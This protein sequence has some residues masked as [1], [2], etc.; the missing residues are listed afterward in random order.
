MT[1]INGILLKVGEEPAIYKLSKDID[2]QIKEI[3]A[4]LDGNFTSSR[5]F[6]VGENLSLHIFIN[7]MAIPLG[8]P[9]NRRFPEPDQHEI[10]FGNALF[11][12]LDDIKG[13]EEGALQIPDQICNLF[14]E[15][16]NENFKPCI[17]NEK[18]DPTSE[19]F[20]ENVGTKEERRF[21]WQEVERPEKDLTFI[22][23]GS[24]RIV[25]DGNCDTYEIKGRYFKQVY[26][27]KEDKTLQ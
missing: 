24:V 9:A 19:I 20:V 4:L 21:K 7:D 17:G 25:D 10:I 27:P 16:L 3:A 1:T 13:D 5:L 11:L 18:P 14:I 8:L 2:N 15:K 23:N 26:L 6:Q 22:G 12:L